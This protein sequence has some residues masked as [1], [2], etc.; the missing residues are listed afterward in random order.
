MGDILE[1]VEIINPTK[2][3][4]DSNNDMLL[5]SDHNPATPNNEQQTYETIAH[6]V[7]TITDSGNTISYPNTKA[8]VEYFTKYSYYRH[9]QSTGSTTW[10]INHNLNR[11][12]TVVT[13]N[14]TGKIIIGDVQYIDENNVVVNFNS[15]R[16]GVAEIN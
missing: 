16:S 6:K 4:L 7:D 10:N 11:Y 9:T 13:R 5:L 2:G 8:V 1:F 14:D 3:V 12:P 15:P